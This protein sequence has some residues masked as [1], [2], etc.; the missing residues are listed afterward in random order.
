M[1][2]KA[3]SISGLTRVLEGEVGRPVRDMTGLTGEYD[4]QVEYTPDFSR[5][6]GNPPP[7]VGQSA[8]SASEPGSNLAT[9]I[10]QQLGLRLVSAT[11][12]LDVVVIDRAERVPSDN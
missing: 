12:K 5:V 10:Q 4:F 3:Q 2:A 11:A 7:V 9:A 6:P 8:D 1:V